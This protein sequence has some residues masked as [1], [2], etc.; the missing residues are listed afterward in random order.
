MASFDD[1][2]CLEGIRMPQ[3]VRYERLRN[4]KFGY[5]QIA[6]TAI[7]TGCAAS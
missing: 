1:S 6:T 2:F 7:R 5:M 4:P 3:A